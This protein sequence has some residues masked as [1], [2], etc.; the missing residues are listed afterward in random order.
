M[1]VQTPEIRYAKTVDGVH[2]AY[3]VVGDGPVDIVLV[4][5]LTGL[6]NIW[7][8]PRAAGFFRGIATHGQ[9]ILLDRRG[10]G[11]SDHA[12]EAARAKEL[13]ARMDD[14][15]SVRCAVHLW[16]RGLLDPAGLFQQHRPPIST[17]NT[18]CQ[19]QVGV[20]GVFVAAMR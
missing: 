17:G 11:Q 18:S 13:D 6:D 3:Q 16:Q 19:P 1:T 7:R 14:V 2:I 15:H 12:S 4:G 20:L 9:L 8:W 5:W 10:T